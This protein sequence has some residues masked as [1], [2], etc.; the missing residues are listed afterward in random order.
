MPHFFE[1]SINFNCIT[2]HH[3]LGDSNFHT[4]TRKS[5]KVSHDSLQSS[6]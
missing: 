4:T 2:L 5:F 6:R 3:N 1:T